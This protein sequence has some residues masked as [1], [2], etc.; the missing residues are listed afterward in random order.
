MS[1]GIPAGRNDARSPAPSS[2]QNTSGCRIAPVTRLRWRMK[3]AISRHHKVPTCKATSTIA[4]LL[5]W[6]GFG[7]E[8]MARKMHEDVF[9][10]RLAERDRFD[11]VAKRIDH[12]AD[13][14]VS[15]W[16]FD[17]E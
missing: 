5:R 16:P 17:P 7:D 2:S 8:S 14:F 10:R 6:L 1:A 12:V 4:S 13:D 11:F 9:Q 15:A 3:R